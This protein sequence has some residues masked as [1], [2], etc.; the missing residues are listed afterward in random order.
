MTKYFEGYLPTY[1]FHWFKET[2]GIWIKLSMKFIDPNV[3][4]SGSVTF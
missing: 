3:K 2:C 4:M 1:I